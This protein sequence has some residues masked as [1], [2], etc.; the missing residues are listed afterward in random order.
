MKFKNPTNSICKILI[1][2]ALILLSLIVV[3]QTEFTIIVKK[4]NAGF[5]QS[6]GRLFSGAFG[7]YKSITNLGE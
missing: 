3:S 5:I 1:T 4:S 7:T 2:L 6:I